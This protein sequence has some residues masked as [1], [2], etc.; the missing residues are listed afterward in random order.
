MEAILSEGVGI[1][2]ASWT[3]SW[4][5]LDMVEYGIKSFLVTNI[6]LNQNMEMQQYILLNS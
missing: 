2:T 1:P 3:Y 5:H 4:K 6:T